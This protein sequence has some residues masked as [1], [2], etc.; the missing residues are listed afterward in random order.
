MMP[1][2]QA[3]GVGEAAVLF[4]VR[5]GGEEEDLGRDVLG[6]TSPRSISGAFA[7]TPPSR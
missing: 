6:F 7:R 1:L 5:R 3:L 4:G 2:Q